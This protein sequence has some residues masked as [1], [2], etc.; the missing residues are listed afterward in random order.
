MRCGL[1][2]LESPRLE[3]G[4]ILGPEGS[5]V[6]FHWSLHSSFS[7]EKFSFGFRR[8][9]Q[10]FGTQGCLVWGPILQLKTCCGLQVYLASI[11]LGTY[12]KFGPTLWSLLPWVVFASSLWFRDHERE[13]YHRHLLL[14]VL[15]TGFCSL[16]TFCGDLLPGSVIEL[17]RLH[18]LCRAMSLSTTSP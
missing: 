10:H 14:R 11:C 8:R 9:I 17:D 12:S 5:P 1:G 6:L 4:F 16:G 15:W 7:P 2:N 18:V 13:F 3:E